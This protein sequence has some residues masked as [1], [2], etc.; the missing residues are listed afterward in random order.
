MATIVNKANALIWIEALESG[1]FPQDPQGGALKTD[2][3]YCCLGVLEEVAGATWTKQSPEDRPYVSSTGRTG[4]ES[5]HADEWLGLENPTSDI[6]GG[7]ILVTHPQGLGRVPMEYLNDNL[8]LSFPEI[9][10]QL[11]VEFDLPPRDPM[12][13]EALAKEPTPFA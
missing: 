10:A 8:R 11:R 13:L 12:N 5:S 9:A 2:D 7:P 6:L 3:G 4:F 1:S